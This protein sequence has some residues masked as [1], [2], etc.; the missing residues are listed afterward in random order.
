MAYMSQ[1]KKA[2][3]AP[4]IKAVL[5]KFGMKGS[6]S[7]N[8]HSTLVCNVSEGPLDIIGN[9][10]EIAMKK[11]D[12]FYARDKAPKPNHIQ[13]NPYWISE[14]YSGKV[15]QFVQ[16]LKDAMDVGNHDRSDIQ[17]DYFDVGWYI[18]INIGKWD[19]PFQLTE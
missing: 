17:T 19:K 14:N 13:V 11:P 8:N 15:L 16:A 6:I 10:Y 4:G 18:D 5:K 2:Q 12:T 1:E 9:M 3:L 7:V